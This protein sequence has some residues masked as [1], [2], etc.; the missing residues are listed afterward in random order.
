ML[1]PGDT[2]ELPDGAGSV[3]LEKV[4]RFAN[5]QIAYDPGKEIALAAA[6][7]LLVGLT[8]SLTIPRRRWWMRI[9]PAQD[10]HVAVE[11]GGLSLTQR[12]LPRRD[13]ELLKTLVDGAP[14]QYTHQQMEQVIR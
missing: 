12:E 2:V 7:M 14:H 1:A 6:V 11:F 8:M 9:R 13:L 10:G 4:V 5:F 3:T